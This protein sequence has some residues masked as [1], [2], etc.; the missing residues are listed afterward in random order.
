M[1]QAVRIGVGGGERKNKV[2]G[3]EKR[4]EEGGKNACDVCAAYPYTVQ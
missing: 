3:G 1:R 2:G 4:G